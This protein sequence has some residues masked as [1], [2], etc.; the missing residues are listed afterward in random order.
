MHFFKY[1]LLL[2]RDNGLINANLEICL[3][4]TQMTLSRLSINESFWEL[5]CKLYGRQL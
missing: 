4:I 5:A 3:D 1:L 2:Y